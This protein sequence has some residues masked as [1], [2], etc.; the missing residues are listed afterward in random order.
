[1]AIENVISDPLNYLAG[2]K[3]QLFFGIG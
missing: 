3:T 2:V 1:M